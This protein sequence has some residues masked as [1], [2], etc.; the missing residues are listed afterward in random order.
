[1]WPTYIWKLGKQIIVTNFK[2][3]ALF[4][5]VS[6]V[7]DF[8]TIIAHHFSSL[9]KLVVNTDESRNKTKRK[10]LFMDLGRLRIFECSFDFIDSKPQE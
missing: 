6:F 10:V 7:T 2:L 4:Y 3:N 5:K 1:M 9:S 8:I